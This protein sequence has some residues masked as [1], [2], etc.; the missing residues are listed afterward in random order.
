MTV[1]MRDALLV[2]TLMTAAALS[3]CLDSGSS[4][5]SSPPPASGALPADPPQREPV[6]NYIAAVGLGV[7][8]LDATVALY[9]NGLGLIELRRDTRADRIE[10]V[11]GAQGGRGSQVIL[12]DYTD[13]VG[14]NFQQNPG[15]LVFYTSDPAAY[16]Q[17]FVAA[18]GRITLPPAPQPAFGGTVVGFGRDL[19]NNL[20]EIVG[21]AGA[22]TP[23]LGAFGLGVSELDA[24]R[25]FYVEQFGLRETLF[26]QIPGQYD[27]YILESPV[28]G[29]SALVLMNWTNGSVRNYQGN[30]IKLEFASSSPQ[31]LSDGLE[32]QGLSVTRLPDQAGAGGLPDTLFGFAEDADGTLLEFR[33]GIRGYLQAAAI[34]TDDPEASLRFYI[35]GLGMREIGRRSRDN[36]DEVVLQSADARG[37]DLV[38]MSFTDGAP[39]NMR[40]NPGKLVFYVKDPEQYAQDMLAAG[41]RVTVPPAFQPGLNVVVGFGRD[42]DNNLIEFVGSPAA[43]HSYF[44]AFGIGVSNLEAARDFYVS[45]MGLREVLFLPIP[46]Q[47]N[48]YILQGQGGSALVLMNWTNAI[49]RNYTDNPVK[50][51]WRSLSPSAVGGRIDQAGGRLL[52][53]PATDATR[54]DETVAYAADADGTLLELLFAPWGR[55]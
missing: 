33:Q 54:N 31:D 29:S 38:I 41:G 53:E 21:D 20:I 7:G 32:G 27:E 1:S 16:A 10:V 51:E 43:T 19:D 4:S 22:A 55:E 44:G 25:D 12:M 37:S 40:Q 47:Y 30:P 26:L 5:R 15:K 14:R 18:G 48:E 39:R 23:Y 49:P 34:G 46:G 17:Q 9:T 13:G 36:R 3:G 50:V 11:L 35:D 28:P 45:A 6:V 52:Q 42:P 24:A 8:Q 2:L